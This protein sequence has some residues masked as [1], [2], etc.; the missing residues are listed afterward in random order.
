[1]N[2]HAIFRPA[3]IVVDYQ[4]DFLPP[5]GSLAVP[6]ALS[7]APVI[8]SLLSLPFDVK[9]ATL[10][11]H[12]RNHVSFAANHAEASPF[13]ST[14]L[15]THPQDPSRSYE[16]VLWPIHCVQDTF[17][18][19][20][21]SS[22]HTDKFDVTLRKG[23][24]Q[25]VEMYSAF[26]DD[27]QVEDSGATALLAYKQISHV[28]VVGVAADYCVAATARSAVQEGY[29]TYIV[30]NGTRPVNAASWPIEKEKLLASGVGII[31]SDGPEVARVRALPSN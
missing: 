16:T 9:I 18:A 6:D 2:L 31:S 25:D 29:Q 3:L 22:L 17:G 30:D 1:M 8:N 11:W 21:H 10:D 13:V 19:Q 20:H 24:N 12:P 28:F 5:N 4:N 7:I 27:F 14:A 15:V 26:Y 23:M